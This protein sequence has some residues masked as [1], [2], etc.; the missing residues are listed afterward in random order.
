MSN[1]CQTA[2][3]LIIT[4]ALAAC[5][6]MGPGG[7]A[8]STGDTSRAK[9]SAPPRSIDHPTGATAGEAS[10]TVSG[11][12]VPSGTPV[13]KEEKEQRGNTPPGMDRDGHGPA[14]GAIIDP[15]GAATRGK[16]Y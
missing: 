15:T 6:P 14:D 4:A 11:S 13:E 8:Y 3:I 7:V 9:Q 12:M 2:G 16:P 1:P 5:A 10:G